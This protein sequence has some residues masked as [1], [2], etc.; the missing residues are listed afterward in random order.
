MI[1]KTKDAYAIIIVNDQADNF[2]YDT[3][4]YFAD[5]I[6]MDPA[7]AQFGKVRLGTTKTMDVKI[8]NKGKDSVK[9]KEITLL[10]KKEYT[11]IAGMVP[12]E[13]TLASGASH[14]VTIN[15]NRKKKAKMTKI[16]S[17]P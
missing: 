15:R 2:S 7:I 11:I 13:L 8:I 12:P 3:V 4:Y 14:S 16:P 6:G 17:L 10:M 1:D 9:I 5:K